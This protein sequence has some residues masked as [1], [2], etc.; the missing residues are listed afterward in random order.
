MRWDRS[1]YG[2]HTDKATSGP[3]ETWYFA[4]GSE[5]FFRTFLLLANPQAHDN[6]AQVQWLREGAPAISRTYELTASSRRTIAAADDPELVNQAFGITVTFESPGV[7]ERAMYFGTEPIFRGGHE[8]AGVTAPSTTW[9]LAE[10]ATGTG[11]ETFVLVSNPGTEAA[12]VTFTFL[13]EDGAPA[14]ITRTVAPA[15]RITI[16]P[17]SENLSIPLGPV[18]TQIVATQPVIA[19]RAQYWPLGPAEWTEAHNSFGVTQAATKWGLA[20]GRAGGDADYQTYILLA[21]AGTEPAIVTL[22]FLGD[23][24]LPTPAT[25]V[26]TVQP[27]RRVNVSVVP[28]GDNRQPGD[29]PTT[30]GALIT[31]DQPI[32]VERAMYWNANGEVWAAGTNATATRLP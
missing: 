21:N 1:G 10:G 17:E 3:A 13:P 5:G 29:P 2:G 25:K 32:V 6:V 28:T 22:T 19:E 8:S 15:S 30:F 11:F 27:Q 16:N 31:S 26:V 9:L 24:V 12:D 4:E 18:A 14:S 7:A 20:E 23:G